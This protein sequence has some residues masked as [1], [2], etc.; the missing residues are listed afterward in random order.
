MKD[1]IAERER[2]LENEFFVKENDQLLQKL[3]AERAH[4]GQRRALAAQCGIDD[5]RLLDLLIAEGI[6]PQ[7]VA[8]LVVVPLVTVAWS[9]HDVAPAERQEILSAAHSI[10][11]EKGTPAHEM[12]EYWLTHPP[13]AALRHAWHEFAELLCRLLDFDDHAEF[14]DEI[15]KGAKAVAQAAGGVLGLGPRI[16]RLERETIDRFAE[17]LRAT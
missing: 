13:S 5:P 7:S 17:A 3:R 11:I 10:G 6:G 4:E 12:I 16:S 8:A 2:A 1:M 14:V 15:L 9:D